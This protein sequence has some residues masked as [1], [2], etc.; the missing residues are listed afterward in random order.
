MRLLVLIL[1]IG[2]AWWW[3]GP[4]SNESV[5]YPATCTNNNIQI[6]PLGLT[7][8]TKMIDQDFEKLRADR[9]NC[10]ILPLNRSTYILNEARGEVYYTGLGGP[11]KLIDCS[12][13]SRSDW[14]CSYSDGIGRV[15]IIDG[16]K[17][18]SK[19]DVTRSG[20]IVFFSLRRWQWWF[21]TLYWWVGEPQ[22]G[23][24]IPEQKMAY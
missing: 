23:W 13:V 8:T 2:I 18:I 14:A 7:G 15:V 17:A 24:L 20:G 6:L 16:I 10:K 1:L 3:A 5:V 22:G 11:Q 4:S 12:I 9:A 19:N 21:A